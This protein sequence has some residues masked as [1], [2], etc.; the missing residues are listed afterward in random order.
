MMC[1]MWRLLRVRLVFCRFGVLMFL[2]VIG[3]FLRR[4]RKSIVRVVGL[5]VV[6]W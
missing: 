4:L 3:S 5:L 1:L 2:L 6:I